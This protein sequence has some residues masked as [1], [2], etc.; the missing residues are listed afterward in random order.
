MG[1]FAVFLLF[2]LV[3]FF[4]SESEFPKVFRSTVGCFFY[5][6]FVLLFVFAVFVVFVAVFFLDLLFLHFFLGFAVL[7]ILIVDF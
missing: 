1:V 6:F 4:S 3:L 7:F 5:C 2:F